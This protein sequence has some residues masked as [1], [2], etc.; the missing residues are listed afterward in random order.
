MGS[1][2]WVECVFILCAMYYCSLCEILLDPRPDQQPEEELLWLN[3]SGTNNRGSTGQQIGRALSI[4][5]GDSLKHGEFL[6]PFMFCVDFSLLSTQRSN[7]VTSQ[8][9]RGNTLTGQ[10]HGVSRRALECAN[11]LAQ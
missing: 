8:Q 6:A 2:F 10:R 3:P 5:R 7:K 1:F 4:N 11:T 9:N